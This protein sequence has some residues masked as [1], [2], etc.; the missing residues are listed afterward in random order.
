[1]FVIRW[2]RRK[3][4]GTEEILR[5]SPI[6]L[7]NRLLHN[8]QLSNCSWSSNHPSPMASPHA[9]ISS[10]S[11]IRSPR[12]PPLSSNAVP[13]FLLHSRFPSG[14][15]CRRLLCR[16][17]CRA[18]VQQAA[19]GAPA[20]YAKEMERLSAKESLLLAV[21]INVWFEFLN[22]FIVLLICSTSTTVVLVEH[23]MT[24]NYVCVSVIL[25]FWCWCSFIPLSIHFVVEH[26]QR[27]WF[28]GVFFVVETLPC[29]NLELT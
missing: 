5:I 13:S 24:G 27:G 1:M 3:L 2:L 25:V 21:S 4:F 18:M 28:Y 29:V 22:C 9:S 20:I 15:R 19:Q 23:S 16:R 7:W 17:L 12:S 26:W 11:S 14:G 10:L 6:R 8:F